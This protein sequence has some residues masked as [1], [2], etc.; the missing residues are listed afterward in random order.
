MRNKMLFTRE[1]L[2]ADSAR[3][4]CVT[5]MLLQ[6]I[7]EVLLPR[8]RFL[9]EITTM[10]RFAGMYPVKKYFSLKY[11]LSDYMLL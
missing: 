8:K 1:R 2:R 10:R 9:A 11:N 3:V 7:S 4:R 6:V 5:S